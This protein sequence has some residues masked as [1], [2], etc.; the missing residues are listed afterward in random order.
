[1]IKNNCKDF[2]LRRHNMIK[3]LTF[4]Q[5]TII[6]NDA[7]FD[8]KCSEYLYDNK[9]LEL[10]QRIDQ[11][12]LDI[13]NFTINTPF[14]YGNI[15]NLSSGCK[16]ILNI[17]NNLDRVFSVDECEENVLD[18]IFLLND[19][20]IYMSFPRNF[21]FRKGLQLCIDDKVTVSCFSDYLKYWE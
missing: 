9:A 1:M 8:I 13:N 3:I 17:L 4:P 5:N 2:K 10:I 12:T 20:T 18:E 7:F 16:T 6:F 11:A 21:K 19:I 15:T 14:G